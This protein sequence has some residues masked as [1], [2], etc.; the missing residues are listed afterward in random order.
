MST[1]RFVIAVAVLW[2]AGPG[3]GDDGGQGT[4]APAA[5]APRADASP[6]DA[7]PGGI[8]GGNSGATCSAAQY[9]DFAQ[10]G[11]GAADET[12]IC[13]DRPTGCPDPVFEATC[14]CDGTI[15]GQPCDAYLAG[16]DLNRYGTCPVPA[17]DFA[18]G[19]LQC[20][21]ETEYCQHSIS[22]IG[23]EP[24]GY[25]CMAI[26]PCPSQFPNCACLV[27]EPCGTSCTGDF[28]SGLTLT[29]AG[30]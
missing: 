5:D 30:G 15:Y 27:D 22:D 14:G 4:D 10:N 28:A 3:C 11:C 1:T 29:C 23:G 2:I 25:A 7:P 19:W 21:R 26:P 12:G 13:T 24:D 9:C 20:N 17:E 6:T 8:C 16:T 18:C